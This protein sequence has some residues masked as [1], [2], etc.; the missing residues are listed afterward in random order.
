[1]LGEPVGRQ[2]RLFYEFDLEDMVPDD[3]SESVGFTLESGRDHHSPEMMPRDPRWRRQL[4]S[5]HAVYQS[6][7]SCPE[8]YRFAKVSIVA[9][10]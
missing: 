5:V 4:V 9:L 10:P 7:V 8:A 3:Q 1:M 6:I 2:D